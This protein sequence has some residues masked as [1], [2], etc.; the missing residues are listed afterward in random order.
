MLKGFFSLMFSKSIHINLPKFSH[1]N[2]NTGK[3]KCQ[4]PSPKHKRLNYGLSDTN[5]NISNTKMLVTTNQ[6]L[7]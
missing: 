6:K 7:K 3:E 4:N 1:S 2:H 5:F